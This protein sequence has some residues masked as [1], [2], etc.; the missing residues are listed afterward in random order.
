[1]SAHLEDELR[2]LAGDVAW[3]ATPDVAAT[4]PARLAAPA[5]RRPRRRRVRL[6]VALAAGLLVVLALAAIPPAR[7]AVL[8]V[9][10]LANGERLRPVPRVPPAPRRGA[11][12]D[13]PGART[14]LAAAR[15][16]VAFRVRVPRALGAPDAVRVWDGVPGGAVVLG[17]GRS[18]ALWAF[19]GDSA[20]YVAKLAGPGSVVRATHVG[21]AR[22]TWLTGAPR[23]FV[24]IDRDGRVVPGTAAVVDANVLVW[25]RGRV[26]YRLETRARLGRARAIAR[27][28]R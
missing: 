3:P 25:R 4:L 9:V 26:A 27:S 23:G 12:A 18:T 28:V 2:A 24:V 1:M 6:R 21:A 10:G 14:T 11:P 20:R 8:D 17:Y 22:A 19:E 15:A 7:S 16:R 5:D 13:A